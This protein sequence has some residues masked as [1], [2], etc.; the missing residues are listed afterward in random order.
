MDRRHAIGWLVLG[1]LGGVCLVVSSPTALDLVP[2]SASD[3]LWS[4]CCRLA[5]RL[6]WHQASPWFRASLAVAGI[7][8]LA[9][10]YRNLALRIG[11]TRRLVSQ[12]LEVEA[13]LPH[14]MHSSMEELGLQGLVQVVDFPHPAAFCYGLLRPRICV[15]SALVEAMSPAQLRAILLHERHHMLRRHP[16][17]T[18][19]LEALADTLFF[20]PLVGELR[21]Q[22]RTQMELEADRAAIHGAGRRSLAGALH[23]LLPYP[24]SLIPQSGVALNS[25]SATQ[26]RI[27]QLLDGKPHG[28]HP[29]L[30]G[31]ASIAPAISLV[32]LL[33]MSTAG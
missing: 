25:L 20:L 33:L 28:W 14:S 10:A 1:G 16:L 5:E 18:L 19:L 31:L 9:F 6:P 3:S 22:L 13:P 32:C 7:S 30:T 24:Q 8:L 12:F 17:K 2:Y 29:S 21:D 27:D 15:S 23:R 4:L 11:R 26:A